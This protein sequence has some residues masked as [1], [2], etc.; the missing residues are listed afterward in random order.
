M[1]SFAM[2]PSK[3]HRFLMGKPQGKAI[4]R[5]RKAS[6]S[7]A[8]DDSPAQA[9]DILSRLDVHR[10]FIPKLLVSGE[11]REEMGQDAAKLFDSGILAFQFDEPFPKIQ[12][13][14]RLGHHVRIR[15]QDSR[16]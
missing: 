3:I 16:V 2:K 5:V 6:A 7:P 8:E 4:F 15:K 12:S 1:N 14:F 13:V 10:D 9:A 11:A